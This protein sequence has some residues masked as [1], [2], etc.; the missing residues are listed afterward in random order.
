ML[1]GNRAILVDGLRRAR[2]QT[3]RRAVRNEEDIYC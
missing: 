3:K 2:A 1:E